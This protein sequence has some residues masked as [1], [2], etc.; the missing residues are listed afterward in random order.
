M[1]RNFELKSL[2]N[3]RVAAALN[4]AMN[5]DFV[6]SLGIGDNCII[7]EKGVSQV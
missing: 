7:Q 2:G 4:L 6:E 5:V 1:A 3:Q